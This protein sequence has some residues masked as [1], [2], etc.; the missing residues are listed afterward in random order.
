MMIRSV[1]SSN[2]TMIPAT[3]LSIF[4]KYNCAKL[5]PHYSLYFIVLRVKGSLR[6]SA[7]SF[8]WSTMVLMTIGEVPAPETNSEFAFVI[9]DLLS[10]VLI[11]VISSSSS[12]SLLSGVLIIATVVG[13]IGS[14]IANTN[15]MRSEFQHRLDGIKT[16]LAFRKVRHP[17][18]HSF[19]LLTVFPHFL[20]M[21]VCMYVCINESD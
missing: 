9:V 8:Y 19:C 20:C 13:N 15:A 1:L 2:H 16:Y 6:V 21:Y 12:S 14:M 4:Q 17:S 3:T 10:G 11:I 7:V 5:S 18:I